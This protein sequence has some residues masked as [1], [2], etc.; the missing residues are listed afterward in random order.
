[1]PWAPQL[2]DAALTARPEGLMATVVD[3]PDTSS[4]GSEYADPLLYRTL[5]GA[6][7]GQADGW[8]EQ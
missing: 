6:A 4:N 8:A 2:A 7:G 3:A 5:N 1:M